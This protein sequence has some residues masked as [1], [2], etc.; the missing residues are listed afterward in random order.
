MAQAWIWIYNKDGPLNAGLRAVGL[1]SYAQAWLGSFTWALPAV[2]L[3]G[4]WVSYGLCMV[5]FIAGAQRI[6]PACTR[7]RGWTAPAP[8]AS[9][10]P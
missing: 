9:S 2:G 6:S 5:L 8:S 10:S 4:T 1:G 7:R 3:V